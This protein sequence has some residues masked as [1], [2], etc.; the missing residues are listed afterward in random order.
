LP[1]REDI[2]AND[3]WRVCHSFNSA[4]P[5]WLVLVPRRHITALHD[6]TPDEAAGL[7]PLIRSLSIALEKVV[8]C[9]KTYVMQYAEGEGFEHVHFHIVP[10][11]DDF[12]HEQ[13]ATR[14]FSFLG[15]DPIPDEEMDRIALAIRSELS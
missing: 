7:G 13:R 9:R 3:Y 10:R 2:L 14:V 12:T 15:D 1:P 11:M 8:G 6:L 4:L 5:G